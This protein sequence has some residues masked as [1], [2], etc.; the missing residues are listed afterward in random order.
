MVSRSP[1][2]PHESGVED[3]ETLQSEFDRQHQGE[4]EKWKHL[5]SKYKGYEALLSAVP[6]SSVVVPNGESV[7]TEGKER[8][9]VTKPLILFP[10]WPRQQTSRPAQWPCGVC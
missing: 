8:E 6:D 1:P 9:V 5:P 3:S 10:A 7:V 4:R 2:P